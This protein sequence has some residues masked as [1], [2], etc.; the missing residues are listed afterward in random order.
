M[1]WKTMD[2]DELRVRFVAAAAEK[3]RP[4]GALCAEYEISRPTGYLS[5]KRYRELG[6]NG[7]AEQSRKPHRSTIPPT[8][9]L[10]KP[11]TPSAACAESAPQAVRKAKVNATPP[12]G[13]V[14]D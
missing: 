8:A 7:F 6:V 11:S 3:A 12:I 1:A 9:L 5:L 13:T 14:Q 2:V 10:S 4:F